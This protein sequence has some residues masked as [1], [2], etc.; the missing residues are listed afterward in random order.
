LLYVLTA[1]LLGAAL[2]ILPQWIYWIS[3]ATGPV[4]YQSFDQDLY[5]SPKEWDFSRVP[6]KPSY[7]QTAWFEGAEI[8]LVGFVLALVVRFL[9]KRRA[10]YPSYYMPPR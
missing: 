5:N 2:M 7:K 10:P 1:T 4:R 3:Y 6:E 9:F 8:F